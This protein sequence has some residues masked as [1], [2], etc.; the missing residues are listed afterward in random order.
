MAQRERFSIGESIF[1][2]KNGESARET[3]HLMSVDAKEAYVKLCDEEHRKESEM[4]YLPMLRIAV[5]YLRALAQKDGEDKSTATVWRYHSKYCPLSECDHALYNHTISII[6]YTK[7]YLYL[8]HRF[9]L[10]MW[11]EGDFTGDFFV[12][13]FWEK[14]CAC[15]EN[16]N[17]ANDDQ[18][19]AYLMK[20]ETYP[21]GVDAL[22][23]KLAEISK[24]EVEYWEE[25]KF[26]KTHL[27]HGFSE[28][29]YS[30]MDLVQWAEHDL[31]RL[32]KKYPELV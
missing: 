11:A 16:N 17:G 27:W 3:W 12:E 18:L 30:F 4:K 10:W 2:Q 1:C 24:D 9:L 8:A 25:A 6:S 23:E 29:R 13:H 31:T 19:R 5:V 28:R 21:G 32:D 26:K 22:I 20:P 15:E 14:L 7:K